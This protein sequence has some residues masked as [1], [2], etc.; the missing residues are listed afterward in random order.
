[1]ETG[2][3][4][5][6]SWCSLS[7]WPWANCFTS[8]NLNFLISNTVVRVPTSR[9]LWWLM[10]ISH[11]NDWRQSR[12]CAEYSPNYTSLFFFKVKKLTFRWP[13]IC[14]EMCKTWACLWFCLGKEWEFPCST[15]GMNYHFLEIWMDVLFKATFF[16]LLLF[17]LC[18]R[19][20]K[21]SETVW[22]SHSLWWFQAWKTEG[23]QKLK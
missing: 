20:V 2:L 23:G 3:S 4:K 5:P 10:E 9:P 13:P 16:I 15:S 6:D 11:M 1:M 14:R 7:I 18:V 12:A 19:H 8:S 21:S 22:S 17:L